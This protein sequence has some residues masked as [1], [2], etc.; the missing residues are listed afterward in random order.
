[1]KK[2]TPLIFLLL[3]SFYATSQVGINTVE[4]TADLDINGTLRVRK[5]T[6]SPERSLEATSI[7]GVDASGNLVE[8]T[9]DENLYLE[10]NVIKYN[11]RQEEIYN[12]PDAVSNILHDAVDIIW[13]G[14]TGNGRPTVRITNTNGDLEITGIDM[15]GFASPMDA[16]GYTVTLYSVSGELR[17]KS[18][19]SNSQTVNQFLLADGNDVNLKRYE[20]VKIM[21]DG[22]LERW[23][24]VSRH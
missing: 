12:R 6:T 11:H 1:M 14:G 7:I 21:Y 15:S 4:P 22:Q 16:D 20:M 17:L 18:E 9:L 19:D 24:V 10:N 3:I 2:I 8:V 23:L 5:M 13:P